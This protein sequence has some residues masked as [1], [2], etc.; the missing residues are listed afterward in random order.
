VLLYLLARHRL[1]TVAALAAA[2]SFTGISLA[3]SLLA[4]YAHA[5]HY[6][7][8][9]AVGGLLALERA[10]ATTRLAPL[11]AAGTLFAV[12]TLKKQPGAVFGAFGLSWIVWSWWSRP[13]RDSF[14]LAARTLAF[15]AGFVTPLA[16]TAAVLWAAGTFDDFWFSTISYARHYGT[17]TSVADGLLRLN[18]RLGA[19]APQA[20]ALG[21]LVLTGLATAV[22]R[23][24][25]R[26]FAALFLFSC[27]G[28]AAGMYFRPHYFI[29]LAPVAAL[30]VAV[31]VEDVHRYAATSTTRPVVTMLVGAAVVFAVAQSLWVQRD[32]LFRATPTQVSRAL[33]FASPFPEALE[34]ARYLKE[35]TVPTDTI[36]VLGSEPEIFFYAGRRSATRHIYM[37]WLMETHPF[38]RTMQAQLIGEIERARPPYVVYVRTESSWDRAVSSNRLIFEWMARFIPAHY[39]RVGQVDILGPRSTRYVWDADVARFDVTSSTHI[40]VLRRTD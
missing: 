36:A 33:Y 2:A 1:G 27:V 17:Y 37:Y 38:A 22:T 25:H 30:L 4:T 14:E 13:V 11:V 29:L 6:V 19:I 34:V 15:G 3:T 9:A 35:R 31:A 20:W 24:R 26:Y 39:A 12:A 18:R 28:V 8:L 10:R 40:V 5:M 32:L 7:V 16:A 23:P 21:L